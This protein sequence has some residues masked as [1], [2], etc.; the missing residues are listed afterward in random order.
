[1]SSK[2]IFKNV[3]IQK[4]AKLY[5]A[6]K[7]VNILDPESFDDLY[8]VQDLKPILNKLGSKRIT[9]EIINE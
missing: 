9:W 5:K 4:D 8:T 3:S 7:L 6:V 1:M 2:V